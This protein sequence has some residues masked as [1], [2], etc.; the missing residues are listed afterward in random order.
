MCK[1]LTYLTIMLLLAAGTNAAWIADSDVTATASSN[2]S[3]MEPNLAC[4]LSGLTNDLH[5]SNWVNMWM[6]ASGG[7]GAGNPNPGTVTGVAWIKFA[8]DQDYNLGRAWIWNDNEPGTAVKR[9]LR[10]VTVEYSTTGSGDGND[11]TTL[12]VYEFVKGD[13]A[14]DTTD[15]QYFKSDF[16]V[17]YRVTALGG[18]EKVYI[19]YV[20]VTKQE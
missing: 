14:G 9:G 4:D 8:F 6:S 20:T 2:S 10:N 5:D 12:G 13:A 18:G 15:S 19:D 7:G 17:R 11:W 16:K 1:K 3:G